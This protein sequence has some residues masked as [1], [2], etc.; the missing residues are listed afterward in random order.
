[1]TVQINNLSVSRNFPFYQT[2]T[3][4]LGIKA[5]LVPMARTVA[6]TAERTR[7]GMSEKKL[8]ALKFRES[9]VDMLHH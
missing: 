3:Y 5:P 6:K 8:W 1:M 7:A 9:L 2:S 4:S